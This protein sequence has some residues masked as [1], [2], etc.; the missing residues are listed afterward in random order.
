MLYKICFSELFTQ[1]VILVLRAQQ[2]N[3]SIVAGT[4]ILLMLFSGRAMIIKINGYET[5]R[6]F[7]LFPHCSVRNPTVHIKYG[8]V[9]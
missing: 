1:R 9:K 2:S 7:Y 6:I 5:Y 3:Q 4:H 8:Y